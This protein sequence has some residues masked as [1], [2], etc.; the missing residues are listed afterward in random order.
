VELH[1]QEIKL[2]I[3]NNILS[4]KYIGKKEKHQKW[5]QNPLSIRSNKNEH[6]PEGE[7]DK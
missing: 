3:K 1:R 6:H 4:R 2:R 5:P 7:K